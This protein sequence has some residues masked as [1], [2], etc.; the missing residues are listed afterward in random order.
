V[1]NSG[2][3]TVYAPP[4]PS[5]GPQSDLGGAG[6][7]L[8]HWTVVSCRRIRGILGRYVCRISKKTFAM[9]VRSFYI[10]KCTV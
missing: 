6:P 4:N 2:V 1:F 7:F 9:S 8:R 10:S 5:K 3:S